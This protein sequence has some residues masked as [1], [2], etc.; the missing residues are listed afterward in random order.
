MGVPDTDWGEIVCAVVVRSSDASLTLEELQA[1]CQGKLARFKQ[2][3]RLECL[4]ALPRT[5]ATRQIQRRLLVEQI[6]AR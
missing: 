6:L 5:A 3:R 4:D 2:P 1:H